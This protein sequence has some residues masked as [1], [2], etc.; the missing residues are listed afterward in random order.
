[1]LQSFFVLKL[2][3]VV[4]AYIMVQKCWGGKHDV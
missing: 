3:A 4:L 1:V 2:S